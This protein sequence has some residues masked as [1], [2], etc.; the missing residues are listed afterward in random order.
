M[1]RV[2]D[3]WFS[4]VPVRGPDGKAVR[5]PDGRAVR[6][7]RKTGKHPDNGGSKDAKRWLACWANPD[8]EEETRAFGK[9]ADAKAYGEKMEADAERGEYIAPDAGKVKFGDLARKHL[10]LRAVGARTAETY[11]RLFRLHIEPAFGKRPVGSIRPSEV[12]EWLRLGSISKLGGSS[13]KQA[14][15][16]VAGTLELAKEDKLCRDNAARSKIVPAPRDEP[17]ER[18]CWPVEQVWRVRDEHPEPYRPVVDCAAGLG[19]RRGCAFALAEEDFDFE[20][21][22]VTVRR[23]VAKIGGTLYFKL[24]KG[25]KTRVVPLP[26]GVAASVKAHMAKY[27]PAE[28][29]LPWMNEDGTVAGDPV[30]ARLL[31]TWLGASDGGP[32]SPKTYGKPIVPVSYENGVWKPALS[33]AGVIPPPVKDAKG[34]LRYPV[35]DAG[36]AGMHA[37]RHYYETALD[38]GGVPL[39]GM[40]DFMGHSRKGKVITIA[41]Y[42]HVTEETFEHA[43]RVIDQGLFRLRPVKAAGTVAELRA[44]R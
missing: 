27:P 10:R 19:L 15:S 44:A 36:D 26:R 6:E 18:E 17:R 38:T 2:K 37:L 31:F 33:R 29:A 21:Q 22:R 11:E 43:R 8:G 1:A 23:Q 40:M 32:K 24:P 20:A 25:G 7:R 39:A 42:S 28:A 5:G 35:G 16:I 41:V 4:E 14:Y 30:T 12:A 13:R 3:L 9:R 34:I